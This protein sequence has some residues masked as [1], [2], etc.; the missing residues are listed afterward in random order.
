[1]YRCMC[2]PTCRHSLILPIF[3]SRDS[4]HNYMFQVAPW[5]MPKV[6]VTSMESTSALVIE[7]VVVDLS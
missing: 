6:W 7:L 1:M 3:L 2:M 4:P 5:H